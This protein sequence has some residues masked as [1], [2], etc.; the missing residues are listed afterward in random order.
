MG[1][2]RERGDDARYLGRVDYVMSDMAARG[3]YS[4][5]RNLMTQH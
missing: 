1:L 4:R 3:F 2:G 5:Y